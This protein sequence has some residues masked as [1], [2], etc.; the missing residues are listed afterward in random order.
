MDTALGFSRGLELNQKAWPG[1]QQGL[2]T[3]LQEHF[4]NTREYIFCI[5]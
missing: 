2:R 5:I 4:E 3:E 1:N